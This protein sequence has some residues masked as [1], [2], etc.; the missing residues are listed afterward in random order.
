MR[1][2]VESGFIPSAF[3]HGTAKSSQK[4]F[5]SALIDICQ[6]AEVLYQL[7]GFVSGLTEKTKSNQ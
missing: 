3:L 7:F 1:R 5:R 4:D 6:K 2:P